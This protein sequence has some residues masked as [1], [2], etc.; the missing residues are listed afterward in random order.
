M[1]DLLPKHRKFAK[2]FYNTKGAAVP[3]VMTLDGKA[4]GGWSQYS[5][6]P[7]N[8]AWVAQAFYWHWRYTMDERFLKERAYPYCTEIATC[9][10]SLLKPGPEGKLKLPLSTSPEIH[11][12]S[13]RA[14]LVPNTNNDLA[15][16]RWLFGALVEMAPA[17]GDGAAAARWQKLLDRL[18]PLAVEGEA[19]AL[20]LSPDESL[21][22]SHRHHA[23]LMA[24]YPLGVLHVEGTE[25]DRK[26]IAASLEQL[27]RLGTKAWVGFGFTW[28]ACLAARAGDADRAVK[29]LEI[30][31][32]AF[33][34]RNGF[35]LNGDYKRLGYSN[36][37]YRPFT[38]EANFAAAQAVHEMLLQ[39]WGG[40]IRVFPAVPRKWADV[41]FRD[42]RAE[43]A[44]AVSAR[45]AGGATTWVRVRADRGGPL[46]L[47]D[48]F[49]GKPVKWNRADVQREGDEYRC[50][51]AAGDV[52]EGRVEAE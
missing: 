50:K 26:I 6:S 31:V 23:H 33:I 22:E 45:R 4:M 32:K 42:L 44:F 48:P 12:N 30:F 36:F 14:W 19:G 9:L 21:R 11:N 49:A 37:S 28:Y 35:N 34:S 47:R 8:G 18:D 29:N 5:L 17:A 38:L 39:S 25:R 52:L 24:I 16:L 51:L 41:S 10:E 3:G 46:R 1:W 20:R 27:D 40:V 2:S 43:G 13:L 7:T 15:L